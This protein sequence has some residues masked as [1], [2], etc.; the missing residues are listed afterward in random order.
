MWSVA[1]NHSHSAGTRMIGN[2]IPL[3][4]HATRLIA[5]Q[6]FPSSVFTTLRHTMRATTLVWSPTIMDSIPNR[7]CSLSKVWIASK[8]WRS[9]FVQGM[10]N[11]IF[12]GSMLDNQKHLGFVCVPTQVA[13]WI[14]FVFYFFFWLCPFWLMQTVVA[15]MF[16][17]QWLT[18][19]LWFSSFSSF[20]CLAAVHKSTYG[21]HFIFSLPSFKWNSATR[22]Y[23]VQERIKP[24]GWSC[25]PEHRQQAHAVHA[26]LEQAYRWGLGQLLVPGSQWLRPRWPVDSARG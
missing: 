14:C 19:I 17:R 5:R 24:S 18:R 12:L 22:V 8:M 26:Q 23:L 20:A 21:F 13:S 4:R 7:P 11:H 9:K 15:R 6:H 2:S 3:T 25:P 16:L 1:V 10:G